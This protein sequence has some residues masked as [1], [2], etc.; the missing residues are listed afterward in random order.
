MLRSSAVLMKKLLSLFRTL[1][2]SNIDFDGSIMLLSP[3]K[4]ISHKNLRTLEAFL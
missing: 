3:Q 1:A 4:V 2:T